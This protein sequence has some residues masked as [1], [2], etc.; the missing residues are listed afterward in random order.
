M[1]FVLSL[2]LLTKCPVAE[3]QCAVKTMSTS[4][5]SLS[6][7]AQH[8]LDSLNRQSMTVMPDDTAAKELVKRE[9]AVNSTVG[10]LLTVNGLMHRHEP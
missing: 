6:Q 8:L 9:Y 2:T 10:L 4:L 5:R 7:D 1:S 3:E